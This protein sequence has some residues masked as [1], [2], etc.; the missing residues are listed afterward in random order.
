MSVGDIACAEAGEFR[1]DSL[2]RAGFSGWAIKHNDS[3]QTAVHC[4]TNF[5]HPLQNLGKEVGSTLGEGIGKEDRAGESVTVTE[6]C[7]GTA[8][9]VAE[10]FGNQHV[11]G[12]GGFGNFR[13][14]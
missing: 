10:V 6:S 11:M 8:E 13:F 4:R 9:V 2:H 1:Q 3:R 5:R 7:Q 14:R 12:G